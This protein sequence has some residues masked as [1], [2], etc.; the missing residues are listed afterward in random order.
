[1]LLQLV[2]SIDGRLKSIETAVDSIKDIK[3]ELLLMSAK[4]RE[5]EFKFSETAKSQKH[6]E[7]SCQVLSDMF[8][9]VKYRGA[10]RDELK[11]KQSEQLAKHSQD[12]SKQSDQL[13]LI[14]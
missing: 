4:M 1:M 2:S 10:K 8:E 9:E 7:T 13:F 6:V 11:N 3:R 12:I 5:L 14:G